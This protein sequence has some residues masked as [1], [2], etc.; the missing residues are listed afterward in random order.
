MKFKSD[1]GRVLT[2]AK[3]HRTIGAFDEK[4]V[5]ETDD[6]YFIGRLKLLFP[7][8]GEK[9]G[10]PAAEKKPAT[11]GKGETPKKETAPKNSAS[12]KP[13]LFGAEGGSVKS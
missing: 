13:E 6:P 5:F 7:F 4:G 9:N 12:K 1:P 2:D 3:T 10:R 8:M 11:D